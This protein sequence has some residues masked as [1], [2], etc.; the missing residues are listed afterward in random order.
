MRET[1]IPVD[2]STISHEGASKVLE[3]HI[4]LEQKRDGSIKGRLV[5]GG[6]KQILYT[7]KDMVGSPT[8]RTESILLTSLLEG[9]EGR[10]VAVIDIPN[11]FVQT[12]VQDKIIVCIRSRIR[13]LLVEM[14]P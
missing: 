2:Y 4:F 12:K 3:S 13:D 7:D 14:F 9:Y 5:S 6:D 1:F 8:C 11:S 10:D